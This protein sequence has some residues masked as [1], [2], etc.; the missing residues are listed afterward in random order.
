LSGEAR[1]IGP[2]LATA[3][4]AGNMI[5]SGVF[6]LPAVLAAA[7][8]SSL[9]AWGVAA[10]IAMALALVF[11]FL[12]ALRPG[13]ES[14]TD[15]PGTA[16]HPALGWLAW[17]AY[18]VSCVVGNVA[19]VIV[20]VGYGAAMLGLDLTQM[21]RLA[22]ILAVIW[23]LAG[24][25][26]AGPRFVARLSSATLAIGLA[27]ILAAICLGAVQFDAG[28]FAASWN[29]TGE[30][31]GEVLPPTLLAI[32]WAFLGLESANAIAGSV[33][34]PKRNIA[35]A[36]A[37]GVALAALVYA[38]ATTALFGLMPAAEL[39]K[40]TAPFADVVG[41]IAGPVAGVLIAGA[42]FARTMGCAAGWILVTAETGRAGA[43]RGFL[44]RAVS[45][46]GEGAVP[47]RDVVFT[48]GLMSL[49][50]FAT[51]TPALVE[52]FNAISA[53]TV[54]MFLLLY[55]LCALALVRF[56]GA[57]ER[58]GLKLAARALGGMGAVASVWIAWAA[59]TG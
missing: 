4:V 35:I 1:Q 48:A 24:C 7:G 55:A 2:G 45:S 38:L 34:R 42:A 20:A 41:S 30:P 36:A 53:F 50:A 25:A 9:I 59:L 6:M 37:G 17:A 8:S 16:F 40:S 19:V 22:A 56:A 5:G 23:V 15:Y 11:A 54:Y 52:Q 44:P 47:V 31:L 43:R 32:F 27:P 3:I 26:L 28:I 21:G 58:P 13:T 57:F 10:I 14:L 46:P 51:L 39:A 18:W 12:G 49:V 29:V 33:Q